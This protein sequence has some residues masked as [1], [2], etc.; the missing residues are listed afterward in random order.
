M[1]LDNLN[2]LL[3]SECFLRDDEAGTWP[4]EPRALSSWYP[5]LLAQYWAMKIF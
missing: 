1:A 2:Q 3:F 5:E 4:W